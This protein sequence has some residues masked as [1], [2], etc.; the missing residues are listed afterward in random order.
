M[1]NTRRLLAVLLTIALLV[2]AFP[3]L[4]A[5]ALADGSS[6]RLLYQGHGSLRIT[7][8]EGK[9]IYVD[10]YAGAG[11]DA[12][13]DLILVTHGHNDHNQLQLILTRNPGCQ[14][15]TNT[16]ALVDGV[17]QVFTLGYVTVEAVQAGNNPNHNINVCVGYVLTLS[18]GVSIYVCGDTSTTAQMAELAQRK[19]DYAFFCC[20][21]RYNMGIAEAIACADLVNARHSIPYHIVPGL[22]FDQALAEQFTAKNRLIVAAGEEIMLEAYVP[23]LISAIP[24]ASVEKL[25]GNRNNLTIAITERFEDG[26]SNII[27][28]TISI[29]NNSA[30]TYQIGPYRVYV[31]TKGNDQIRAC[32]I[33]K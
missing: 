20:D 17:Y 16:E 24:K 19:L 27:M 11:Y 30:N 22:L 15:I 13:A 10:P 3:A 1:K 4:P 12:P 28:E 31:D 14:I 25:N 6:G 23:A 5:F 9:V 18:D 29:A 33:V 32:Y 26:A 8:P 7:T 21:G 2:A